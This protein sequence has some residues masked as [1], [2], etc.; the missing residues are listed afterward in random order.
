LAGEEEIGKRSTPQ[1]DF[2]SAIVIAA[3][4]LA[5]MFGASRLSVPNTIFTAPGLLPFLT[6]LTL[7]IMAAGLGIEA[8]RKGGADNLLGNAKRGLNAFLGDPEQRRLM[9]LMAIVFAYVLLVD[10]I[11]FD[12]RLPIQAFDIHFTS[13]EFVSVPVT[14]IV[15]KIYWRAGWA[16][17]VGLSAVVV[18]ALAAVFRYGFLIPLP[19][20]G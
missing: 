9:L 1:K 17:C 19:G 20:A 16:K 15:L 5:A 6:G 18:I 7:F 8:F 10:V 2:A 4:A 13:F 14:A 11:T 12:L 3:F